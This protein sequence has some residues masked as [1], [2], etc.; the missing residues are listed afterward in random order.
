MVGSGI[1]QQNAETPRFISNFIPSNIAHR[2]VVDAQIY[3][4]IFRDSSLYELQIMAFLSD[5]IPIRHRG[6]QGAAFRIDRGAKHV[7]RTLGNALGGATDPR[8]CQTA[9]RSL[10][11]GGTQGDRPLATDAVR[12]LHGRRAHGM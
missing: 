2:F 11:L 5:L 12:L 7:S 10:V 8:P 1:S 9:G 4:T 3:Q 6:L